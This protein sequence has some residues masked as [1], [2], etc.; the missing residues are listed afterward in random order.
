VK[1][2]RR[3]EERVKRGSREGREV[4]WRGEKVKIQIFLLK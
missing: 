1:R 2:E 3:S 4:E